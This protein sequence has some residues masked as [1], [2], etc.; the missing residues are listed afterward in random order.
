MR[1]KTVLLMAGVS[2]PL[3]FAGP[4]SAEFIGVRT[5]NKPV[6]D[7]FTDPNM[8]GVLPIFVVSLYAVFTAGDAA[9]SVYAIQ[10]TPIQPLNVSVSDGTFFQHPLE[11]PWLSPD[12]A[13]FPMFDGLQYDSF[14]TI[15]RK[16]TGGPLGQDLTEI[17]GNEPPDDGMWTPLQLSGTNIAWFAP[18]GSPQTQAGVGEVLIGQFT[19]A[20]ACFNTGVFGSMIVQGVHTF[21]GVV[22]G[23]SF[24]MEFANQVHVRCLWDLNGNGSVDVP[25]L[26][27]LLAAWGTNPGGTPDFDC[28]GSVGCPDLS[29]LLANWGMCHYS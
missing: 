15:G 19:V 16:S 21:G 6:P 13:L 28:S 12:Q 11:R 2:V 23:F 18:P 29:M 3:I 7:Q 8:I 24:Y 14:L 25:D 20:N 26:L 10:G 1:M 22:E 17:T 9:A 5:D 27:A 4:A